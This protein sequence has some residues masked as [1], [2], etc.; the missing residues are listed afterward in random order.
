M[1]MHRRNFLRNTMIAGAA[2]MSHYTLAMNTSNMDEDNGFNDLDNIISKPVLKKELF[3]DPVIIE[4]VDLLR[5]K[6]NFICR[7]IDKT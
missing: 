5:Y 6:N 4:S 7:V 1:I 3:P 2:G